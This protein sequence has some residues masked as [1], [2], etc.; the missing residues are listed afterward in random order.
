MMENHG[1][2]NAGG[3]GSTGCGA[4]VKRGSGRNVLSFGAGA[5]TVSA[6][7]AIRAWRALCS[8]FHLICEGVRP[9]RGSCVICSIVPA[10]LS[11]PAAFA[12][13]DV[14]GRLLFWRIFRMR[15]GY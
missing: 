15:V 3:G 6:R 1:S 7:A 13:R 9:S 10:L 4:V 12:R 5:G 8:P 11:P 14:G 2:L